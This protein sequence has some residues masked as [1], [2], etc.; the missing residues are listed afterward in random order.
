MDNKTEKKSRYTDA[1]RR[2]T[3]KYRESMAKIE[4]I[5]TPEEKEKIKQAAADAG[6]SVTRFLVDKALQG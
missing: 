3:N 1:Q 4:L 5:I 2:A 6:K